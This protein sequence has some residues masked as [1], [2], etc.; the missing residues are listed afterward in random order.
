LKVKSIIEQLKSR[1]NV[2]KIFFSANA[3]LLQIH[4]LR[5][6]TRL[7]WHILF[8]CYRLYYII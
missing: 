8:S 4:F 5:H 6:L 2:R 1:E 3:K 7:L